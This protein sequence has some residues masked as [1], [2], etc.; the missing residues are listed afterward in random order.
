M[1]DKLRGKWGARSS[2]REGAG[3][4]SGWK[5]GLPPNSAAV[6]QRDPV[7]RGVCDAGGWS[8]ASVGVEGRVQEGFL[9]EVGPEL[10]AQ[11]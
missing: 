1:I 10:S 8:P 9:K 3:A 7:Q 2:G 4:M 6:Q 5:L 11:Q